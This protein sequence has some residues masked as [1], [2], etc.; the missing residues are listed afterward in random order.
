MSFT[1]EAFPARPPHPHPTPSQDLGLF[2]LYPTT[3]GALLGS[4]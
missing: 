4:R 3:T 1:P 2:T